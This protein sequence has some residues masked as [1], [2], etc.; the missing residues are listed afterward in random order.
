[1]YGRLTALVSR[2]LE[3]PAAEQALAA[4]NL[5]IEIRRLP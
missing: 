3:T 1:L 5:W 2:E 4:P